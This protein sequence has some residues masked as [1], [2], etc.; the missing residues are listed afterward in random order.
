MRVVAVFEMEFA[1]Y[2][3]RLAITSLAA[4]QAATGAGDRVM[5]LE[6][7]LERDTDARSIARTLQTQLDGN[8]RCVD[9]CELNQAM[10]GCTWTDAAP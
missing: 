7:M 1:E 4:A 5:G 3:Y 9:W 10:F 6:L 2:D 8:Y